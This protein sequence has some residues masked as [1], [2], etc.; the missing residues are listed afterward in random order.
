MNDSIDQP[1]AGPALGDVDRL[2][3]AFYQAELPDPWPRLAL[4]QPVRAPR[5]A[6]R[7]R[8]RLMPYALAASLLVALCGYAVLAGLFTAP[9]PF[10][11]AMG[12]PEVG[13]NPL[14]LHHP[15]KQL[16]PLEH[17]RTPGGG[18]AQLF[19]EDTPG[20]IVINVIGPSGA[21]GPR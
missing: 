7:L 15:L 12:A 4:P 21:K 13:E 3:C 6:P 1:Q 19:E 10:G 8:R 16:S 20:G 9:V 17:Q 18:E 11:K 5:P 14:H 2:L